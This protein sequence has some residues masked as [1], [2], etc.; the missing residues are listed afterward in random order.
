MGC[1]YDQVAWEQ[2]GQ[3]CGYLHAWCPSV[4]GARVSMFFDEDQ[5]AFVYEVAFRRKGFSA[6]FVVGAEKFAIEIDT[7]A[8]AED[9]FE[10]IKPMFQF[11]TRDDIGERSERSERLQEVSQSKDPCGRDRV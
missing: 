9:R 8:F 10:E 2:A 3:V 11:A 4:A 6:Q 7:R 5:K 1:Y